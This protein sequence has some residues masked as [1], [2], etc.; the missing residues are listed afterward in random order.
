MTMNM[1]MKR[2]VTTTSITKMRTNI[3]KT[4]RL[5]GGGGTDYVELSCV[6][7][8]LSLTVGGKTYSFNELHDP[9]SGQTK[10]VIPVYVNDVLYKTIPKTL[11]PLT[12]KSQARLVYDSLVD[13][14]N[15]LCEYPLPANRLAAR[16]Y[17]DGFTSMWSYTRA[18]RDNVLTVS[19]GPEFNPTRLA[20][21]L[22]TPLV[23]AGVNKLSF[24]E[25][26]QMTEFDDYSALAAWDTTNVVN[27]SGMFMSSKL[28]SVN[29]LA[30]WNMSNVTSISQMFDQCTPLTEV[31]LT[32]WDT[33]N[34]LDMSYAFS[35]LTAVTHIDLSNWKVS[36][37]TDISYMFSGDTSL[38]ELNLTG[39]AVP[40][41]AK[42]TNMFRIVRT[43]ERI[44]CSND[45]C[46]WLMDQPDLGF[47]FKTFVG[48]WNIVG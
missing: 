47:D 31:V 38:R 26:L 24:A 13:D 4:L 48:E 10:D 45:I 12:N 1:S 23:G 5:T 21:P 33:S 25:L 11:L 39:W 42:H 3:D 6:D 28:P 44:T 27:T 22:Y 43:L 19:M 17:V 7:N 34:V 35:S 2:T 32:E 46:S 14:E 16:V 20:D 8:D 37:A 41:N 40:V 29:M 9:S 15:Y 30:K 36:N 18:P